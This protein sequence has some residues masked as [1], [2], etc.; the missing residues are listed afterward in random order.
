MRRALAAI[1]RSETSPAEVRPPH[2]CKGSTID[3]ALLGALAAEPGLFHRGPT[4]EALWRGITETP[5]RAL[6][7]SLTPGMRTLETGCGGTTV[8]FAARGALHTVVTPAPDEE[9]RVRALCARHGVSLDAVDFRIGSSD[10]VLV[11]WSE[12]LDF[13]LIDGAHRFPFPML[14]W[15][16]GARNLKPGGRLWLDDIAIPSVHAL[17]AFL[18]GE[19]EWRLNTIH[20][21]KVA[22]FTKVADAPHSDTL[23][24][25]LQRFNDPWRWIFSYMPIGRRWRKWR[26]RAML[27]SRIRRLRA[28]RS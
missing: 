28:D 5:L 4:G 23:D 18:Q 25:E 11:N 14:D 7:A 20:D 12:P 19:R 27:R 9:R 1:P 24:W 13:V 17:F 15:H 3:D 22:E 26:Q 16:Y 2:G 21:D 10:E 6:S 8:V